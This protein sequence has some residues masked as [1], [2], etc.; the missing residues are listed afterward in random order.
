[1][2]PSCLPFQ[3]PLEQA[4]LAVDRL[5]VDRVFAEARRQMSPLE[6]VEGLIGPTLERIGN[7]WEM[8]DAALSQVYMAGRIC[9]KVVEGLF[10]SDGVLREAQP[11][12]AI[13]VFRDF[14]ALGKKTVLSYLRAS[15]Y[16]ITDLGNGLEAD[17]IIR[18]VKAEGID[19]LFLSILM[20]PSA[21]AVKSVRETLDREAPETRLVVGGA[22][23][24]F[25]D[26]L[27]REV[28]ADAMGH[29]AAD[30]LTIVNEMMGVAS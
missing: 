20:L 24:L 22:P 26:Q 9:E 27:W 30:A 15:G 17:A 21:L 10:R 25:D 19:V 29:S 28:G 1:M 16:R 3:K 8:G 14:H 23:F 5:E 6:A 2:S 7:S 13:G 18:R 12:M 11:T 4:L